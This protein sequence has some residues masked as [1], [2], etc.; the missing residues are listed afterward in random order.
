MGDLFNPAGYTSPAMDTL[1]EAVVAATT[2]E[3][4]AAGVRAMDR[5]MRRDLFVV[6]TWYKANYW[7]AYYDMYEHPETLPPYSLGQLDF[8]WFNP[9]KY[10]ALVAAGAFQQ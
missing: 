4:M 1:I 7:V 2:R 6:P 9:E 8:W 5:I 3:E 10:D